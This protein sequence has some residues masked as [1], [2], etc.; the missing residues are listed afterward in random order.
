[1][2]RFDELLAKEGVIVYKTQGFSMKP[3][4][5][6][7]RDIVVIKP[8]TGILKPMDVAFYRRGEAYILH[9]V[10][11]VR[12]GYYVIRGDNTFILE[13]VPFEDV[14][15]VLTEF[16]RKGKSISTDSAGYRR[17]ARIWTA[18]YPVRLLY[19]RIRRVAVNIKHKIFDS[20]GE[21]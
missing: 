1:M 5:K 17:Y 19:F 13:E 9:R 4:L 7:N 12:E 11:E 3:M 2:I 14:L 18:I 20:K 8:V 6:E 16:K 10:L 21:T 15:G